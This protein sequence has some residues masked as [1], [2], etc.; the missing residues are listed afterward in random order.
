MNHL[1]HSLH[2]KREWPIITTHRRVPCQS[3]APCF[4][5]NNTTCDAVSNYRRQRL[6]G[7]NEFQRPLTPQWVCPWLHLNLRHLVTIKMWPSSHICAKSV[8]L[9]QML[10]R[11]NYKRW[12]MAGCAEILEINSVVELYTQT[13][14][15]CGVIPTAN[16]RCKVNKLVKNIELFFFLLETKKGWMLISLQSLHRCIALPASL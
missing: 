10:V 3:C 14:H 15:C 13:L 1:W 8:N 2:T 16:G 7:G 6:V 12:A 9:H 4:L 11:I 5:L